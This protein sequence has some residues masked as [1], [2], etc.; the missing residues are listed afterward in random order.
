MKKF[1]PLCNKKKHKFLCFEIINQQLSDKAADSIG[2]RFLTLFPRKQITTRR[3]R[4]LSDQDIRDAGLSWSKVGFIK[5]L[6]EK[7]ESKE[8]DFKQ[9]P[10]LDNETAIAELT[11]IKG[12]GPWTAEMFLIFSLGREDVF[13]HGDV[14]LQR[15]IKQLYNLQDPSQED[16]EGITAKWSPYR[17]WA[18]LVLWK[19]VDE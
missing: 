12:I 8:I 9:L 10:M 11:A 4:E 13:S 19:I 7:V 14:G 2:K 5:N 18:S 17:S 15:A 1:F 3:V 6:A 16:I